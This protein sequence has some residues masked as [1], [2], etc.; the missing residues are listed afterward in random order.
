MEQ[1]IFRQKS[2]E[3]ISSP[4]QLQQYMRVTGPR[5]W[6]ILAAVIALTAGLLICA[7]T[8]SIETTAAAQVTASG[9]VLTAVLPAG[10]Q[11]V[12]EAGM[13]LRAGGV[14]TVLETVTQN[15]DSS[16]TVTAAA[17]LE[18]GVYDGIVVTDS[19]SPLRFLIN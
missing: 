19:V 6:M 13:P 12:P 1:N 16:Y 17:D 7:C 9:G 18:D 15:E 11:P 4:E 5:V 14:Q 10:T 8:G 2:I 3:R